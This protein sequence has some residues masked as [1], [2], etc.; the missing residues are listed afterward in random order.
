MH[1]LHPFGP[2]DEGRLT[3][4][5]H[6][7]ANQE[8]AAPETFGRL[9]AYV[10]PYLGIIGLVIFFSLVYS[11]ARYGRAYLVKPLFDDVVLAQSETGGGPANFSISDFFSNESPPEAS[12]APIP[13]EPDPTQLRQTVRANLLNIFWA[14]LLVVSLVPIGHFGKDYFAEFVLGRALVDIQQAVC[15]KLLVLPLSFHHGTTRG[16]TLSRTLNDVGRAHRALALIFGDVIQAVIGVVIGAG[17]LFFISWQLTLLTLAMFPLLFGVIG[18]FG[19]RIRKSAKRRQET[20]SDV[21]QRLVEILGGIKVIKAFRAEVAEADAFGRENRRLFRRSMKVVKN[22]VLA[23]SFTE[24]LNNGF[25]IMILMVAVVLVLR[26][27][28]GLSLGDIGAFALV[29]TTTYHPTKTLAKGWTELMDAIPAAERFFALL[30]E[31]PE[32]ADRADAVE[33]DGITQ[34]VEFTDVEFRYGSEPVLDHLSLR[35]NAGEIV[36]IVGRTGAGKTTLADLLLRLHEPTSGSIT[37]D[38]IDVRQ[39]SRDSLFRQIAVVTQTP[40][41]FTGSI[42]ENI[43]YGRPDATDEE[44]EAA[45]RAAYVDEFASALPSGYDTEVGEEGVRLSGGQRQRIT[46]ARAILRNPAVLIFDEATSSLDAKSERY[47]QDSIEALLKDR[48]V[49]LI[50]HRLSTM[51]RADKIA[52]MEEG[53]ISRVGTHEQLLAEDGLYRDLISLHNQD[54]NRA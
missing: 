54:T 14:G 22:R 16:D 41:L 35:V 44:V 25:G 24:A 10:R 4:S 8:T 33:I 26:G 29:M 3:P 36:G 12:D 45:A 40:F 42:R 32:P 15:A 48:T 2:R 46:I 19:K 30:D 1:P 53:R 38:G 34:C 31:T 37:V 47:V 6:S 21:T 51:R 27:Q 50:A 23:R 49:F 39:I 5:S 18:L 43:R 20:L 52:I 9:L 28:W 7:E 13:E 17:M 11:G